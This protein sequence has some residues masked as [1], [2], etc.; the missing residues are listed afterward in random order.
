MHK[1]GVALTIVF[2][3][4]GLWDVRTITEH[5]MFEHVFMPLLGILIVCGGLKFALNRHV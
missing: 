4:V 1:I 2:L 3:I 5:E